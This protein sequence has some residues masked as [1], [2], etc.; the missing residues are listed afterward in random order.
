[1]H[2]RFQSIAILAALLI[3]VCLGALGCGDGGSV[4][5]GGH[6]AV[7]VVER[8][9]EAFSADDMNALMDTVAP[10]DRNKTGFGLMGLINSLSFSLGGIGI[11]AGSLTEANV[12]N[13]EYDLVS[14]NGD[15][16]LVKAEGNFRN[17][18]M[19]IEA[20][21]CDLLDVRREDDG[22]WY[23]DID[24]SERMDRLSRIQV[25]QQEKLMELLNSGDAS[26][27]VFGDTAKVM[28][29]YMDM[30]E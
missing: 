5:I 10:D 25:T 28:A 8:Y 1:M 24:A 4:S 2:P 17:T 23:I 21:M 30:C 13:M 26:A 19:G 15:Y 12:S 18:A 20:P 14:E 6:P 3:V 29:I 27:G 16:A 9:Y 11:D 22:K 7:D